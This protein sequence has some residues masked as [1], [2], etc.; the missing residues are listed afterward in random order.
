[1]EHSPSPCNGPRPTSADGTPK[2]PHPFAQP[3]TGPAITPPASSRVTS[4]TPSNAPQLNPRSCI[5]CRRRKVK[6]NKV[7][8]CSNCVKQNIRCEF[9]SPGRAP[10]RRKVVDPNSVIKGGALTEREGELLKRL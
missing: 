3:A 10:R 1:M 7:N 8:P 2:A 9:P 6:C 5:T 4:S